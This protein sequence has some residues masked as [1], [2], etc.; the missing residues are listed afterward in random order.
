MLIR[1]LVGIVLPIGIGGLAGGCAGEVYSAAQTPQYEASARTFVSTD[2]SDSRADIVPISWGPHFGAQVADSYAEVAT[3]PLVLN[4]VIHELSLRESP[5]TLAGQVTAK[6][7]Q[8]TTVVEVTATDPSPT[9]AARLANAVSTRLVAV[10]AMLSPASSTQVGAGATLTLVQPAK[11]PLTPA[12]PAVPLAVT[13]GLL[14]G[15]AA[16]AAVAVL[17]VTGSNARPSAP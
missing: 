13:I 2:A 10:V 6:R 14:L 11:P 17:R 8:D 15:G 3:S 9:R 5:S 7:L 12:G 4:A 16:G 1:L